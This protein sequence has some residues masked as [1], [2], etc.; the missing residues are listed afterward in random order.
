MEADVQKPTFIN[1]AFISYSRKDIE[2]ARKL[3]KALENYQPRKDLNVPQRNLVVFR[4]EADLTG[5]EYEESIKKQLKNSKK[6][7]VICSPNARKKSDYINEEIHIFA[8]A[9]GASN[10]IPIL[11]SG[12]PNNDAKPEQEDEMAF[13]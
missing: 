12:I 13:P 5:V 8:Q 2:F 11:L 4:D 10:I 9:H 6:M 1:D 3:E 7:I